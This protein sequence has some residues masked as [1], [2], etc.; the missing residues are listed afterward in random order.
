V[1]TDQTQKNY[2]LRRPNSFP[3]EIHSRQSRTLIGISQGQTTDAPVH[4]IADDTGDEERRESSLQE[5]ERRFSLLPIKGNVYELKNW[6]KQTTY[7]PE[8]ASR[9][10]QDDDPKA[11]EE[12]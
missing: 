4:S 5:K 3:Q 8:N 1:L 11:S 2:M 6:K 7:P 10:G 12:T 9:P